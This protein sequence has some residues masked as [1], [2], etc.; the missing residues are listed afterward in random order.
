MKRVLKHFTLIQAL[1]SADPKLRVAILRSAS[2]DF[3]KAIIE[4]ALNVLSGNVNLPPAAVNRLRG[5]RT[6]LRN[7]AKCCGKTGVKRARKQLVKQ[8]G[9]IIPF[10]I[11]VIA[12]FAGLGGAGAAAGI[13]AATLPKIAANAANKATNSVIDTAINRAKTAIDKL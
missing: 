6:S 10:L 5:H 13:A 3:I 12:G 11:P 7:L 9:G 1:K 4:V 8:K 2:D